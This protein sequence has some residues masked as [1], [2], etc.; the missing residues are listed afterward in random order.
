MSFIESRNMTGRPCGQVVGDV[1]IKQPVDQ[2]PH[3]FGRQFHIDLYRGFA[4]EAGGDVVA[5]VDFGEPFFSA[6]IV[7][8]ISANRFRASD[9]GRSV[10]MLLIA[11]VRPESRISPNPSDSR[12][13]SIS[14]KACD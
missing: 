7:S 10:G 11:T 12:S 5:K 14:C 3:F 1:V 2:P 8:S 6:S 13:F 9:A 4:R